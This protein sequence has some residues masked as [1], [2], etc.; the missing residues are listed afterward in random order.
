MA[1]TLIIPTLGV[2]TDYDFLAV[3]LPPSSFVSR[4]LEVR[5]YFHRSKINADC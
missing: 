3:S 1:A 5:D 4:Y 2:I